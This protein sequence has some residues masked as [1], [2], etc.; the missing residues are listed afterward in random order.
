[1]KYAVT[2]ASGRNFWVESK[3]VIRIVYVIRRV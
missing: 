2:E 1:M 3:Q